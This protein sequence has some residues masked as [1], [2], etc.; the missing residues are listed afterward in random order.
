[1]KH[2]YLIQVRVNHP[3]ESSVQVQ[4]NITENLEETDTNETL[5]KVTLKWHKCGGA[6]FA[7]KYISYNMTQNTPYPPIHL[8]KKKKKA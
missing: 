4:Q 3:F 2:G 1:M 5:E 6:E 7:T 8:K